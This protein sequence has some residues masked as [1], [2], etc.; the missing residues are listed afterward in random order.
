MFK[1]NM[2]ESN[3]KHLIYIVVYGENEY[4]LFEYVPENYCS[5]RLDAGKRMLEY[6]K[7][8]RTNFHIVECPINDVPIKK[9]VEI[10]K[11]K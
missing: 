7:S 9:L 1:Q 2:A 6:V 4:G 5:S 11:N 10:M 3:K 8:G